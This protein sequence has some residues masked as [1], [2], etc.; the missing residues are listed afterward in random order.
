[1]KT[2]TTPLVTIVVGTF[3]PA[4]FG[5]ENISE[6]PEGILVPSEESS[7]TIPKVPFFTMGK[8]D[9]SS[10]TSIVKFFS[11]QPISES[12]LNDIFTEREQTHRHA[13]DLPGS[14]PYL[15][16]R[17]DDWKVPVEVEDGIYYVNAMERYVTSVGSCV[18]L[19]PMQTFAGSKRSWISTMESETVAGRNVANLIWK[20]WE[21]EVED[22]WMR[23]AD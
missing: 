20:K 4:Y 1:M 8:N 23:A 22:R 2:L 14:Y 18:T 19:H 7:E 9:I 15:P 13:W 3:N 16:V 11:P 10:S 12:V 21:K 6:V 17:D 5:L